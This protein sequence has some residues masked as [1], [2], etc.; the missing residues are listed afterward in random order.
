MSDVTRI[1]SQIESGEQLA[2]QE[3]LPLVYDELRK[4]AEARM[5]SER[6]DHTLSATAL[7]HEAYVRM[8]D[9]SQVPSWR[10]RGHFFSAAAEAMRR[11]LIESARRK[12][13]FKRGGDRQRVELTTDIAPTLST[14]PS[15][16]LELN[17]ALDQLAKEEPVAAELV[18][19]RMF[20][21]LS[22]TDAGKVMHLSRRKA[23][24]TWEFAEAWFTV[25]LN[26]SQ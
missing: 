12:A 16:L 24:E 3:L 15:R 7:V 14:E 4:L 23:Y 1:L 19:L 26:S 22:V 17:E 5:A 11:I 21:G 6:P 20:A 9:A 13:A 18:K 10:S 2:S 25:S 8:V